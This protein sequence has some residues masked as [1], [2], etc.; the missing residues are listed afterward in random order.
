VGDALGTQPWRLRLVVD[1]SPDASLEVA[2]RLAAADRRIFVT[3]LVRNVGQHEALRRG[4]A[5]EDGADVSAWVL[6]DGDLQDPPEAIPALVARLSAGDV[7]AVFAGRRGRYESRGRLLT[8]QLHRSVQAVLTGLPSDAGAFVA[9][10]RP[11][12]QAVLGLG[13]PSV[14]AALGVSGLAMT[15]VP[16]VRDSRPATAGRSS[17]PSRRRLERSLRTLGWVAGQRARR[18][19]RCSP[20]GR[21]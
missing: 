4:L 19:R 3:S 20:P 10:S 5:S 9:L 12:R 13:G 11:A 14:V 7:G 15:S 21:S 2:T 16:V 8:G 17:W 6:L 1:A 18:S